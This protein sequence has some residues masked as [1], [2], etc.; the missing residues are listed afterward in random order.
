MLAE[1][2]GGLLH[3]PEDPRDLAERLRELLLDDALRQRLGQTGGMAVIAGR[4]HQA[5]AE[6]TIT[7]LLAL[8]AGDRAPPPVPQSNAAMELKCG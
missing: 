7:A 5:M 6:R 3:R 8:M 4:N 2:G 1:L